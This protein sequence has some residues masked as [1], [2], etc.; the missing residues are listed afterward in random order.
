MN[1]EVT[2]IGWNFEPNTVEVA[3]AWRVPLRGYH[4]W[5]RGVSLGFD[6][7]DQRRKG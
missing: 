4:C 3:P 1:A 6:K 2:P 5:T 7:L